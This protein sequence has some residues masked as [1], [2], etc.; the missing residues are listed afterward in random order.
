MQRSRELQKFI[1]ADKT[2]RE[3]LAKRAGFKTAQ[4]YRN[5]LESQS[6]SYQDYRKLDRDTQ[7]KIATKTGYQTIAAYMSFLRS[8]GSISL[9]KS[10]APKTTEKKV[11]YNI[12][13]LDESSSMSGSKYDNAKLGIIEEIGI[14]RKEKDVDIKL[15]IVGFSDYVNPLK[16][17]SLNHYTINK[18]SFGMTALNDAIGETLTS[19]VDLME[20]GQKAV[21]K[22]FT[23]GDENASRKYSTFRVSEIINQS[24]SKGITVVFV[25]T[26]NDTKNA[27]SNYNIRTHNTAVHDNTQEGVKQVFKTMA[28]STVSYTRSY[29]AGASDE[30]LLD[31]FFKKTGKL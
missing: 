19:L 1:K 13:I 27:I 20:N 30:E 4:E 2:R 23:D 15:G 26:E 18:P 6:M 3:V 9:P 5:H 16:I 24:E 22:I 25:G 17:E 21:V 12:F 29:A 14:L 10:L 11:M 8:K 7:L 31:G 28:A